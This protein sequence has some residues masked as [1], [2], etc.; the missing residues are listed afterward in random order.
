MFLFETQTAALMGCGASGFQGQN[1]NLG[2]IHIWI[3]YI[4][5]F[6]MGSISSPVTVVL[7]LFHVSYVVYFMTDHAVHLD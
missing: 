5:T 3:G 4:I 1:F 2:R 7:L 6:N